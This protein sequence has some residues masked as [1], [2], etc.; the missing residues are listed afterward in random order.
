[1]FASATYHLFMPLGEWHYY[2]LLKVDLI[3][4][5]IMIFGLTLCAL[6]VGFHNYKT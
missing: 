2:K 6:F 3:G 4:I 5:G 1:M